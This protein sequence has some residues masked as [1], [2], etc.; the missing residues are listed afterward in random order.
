M[1]I[2]E[3][4][5]IARRLMVCPTAPFFEDGVRAAVEEICA[6]NRLVCRRDPFGNVIVRL[7]GPK[8]GRPLV[9]AAHMDHPGFE[10]VHRLGP[11]RWLARFNGGVPDAYFRPGLG[12]C[13]EP[14]GTAARLGR[15]IGAERV[16]EI[17][18]AHP[19][20][21]PRFAVWGVEDFAVRRGRIHAR[22]CDDLGGVA[23]ILATLI[24]LKRSRA[25]VYV[26]GVISRAEE[27]G[28]QGALTVAAS[29]LLPKDSLV[30]SLETS[31]ELPSVKM[32]QGVII[33]VGDRS[34][35]FDPTAT[36]FLTEVADALRERDS[37]FQFQ[38][39]L[40][41]AGTCEATAYQ[42]FGFQTAAVCVALGNYHNCSPAGR[43]AA[44]FID[45][46]DASSM[47]Q[48]LV[49]TARQMKSWRRLTG[50][51]P[52]RLN[53]LLQQARSRLRPPTA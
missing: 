6:E 23:G 19:A 8:A 4:S 21:E 38:R 43:I 11:R 13:L 24:E 15:R 44:E 51:L 27:V 9:L 52:A 42:E 25:A 14:G 45:L 46:K 39:A 10:I 7:G 22:A 47:V 26:I 28:F 2:K 34:S 33:R 16:F 48:L 31:K 32:G 50:K 29:K 49:E 30:I 35:I 37:R 40:M 41:F 53:G 5:D 36:R 12:V 18:A 1:S 3:F 17:K 20:A